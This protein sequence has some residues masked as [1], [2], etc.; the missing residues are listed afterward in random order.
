MEQLLLQL[1]LGVT[2]NFIYDLAKGYLASTPNP[3]VSELE[4]KIASSL[5]IQNADIYAHKLV[6]FLAK[7]GDIRIEGTRIYA[8]ESILMTSGDGTQFTFG[9]NSKSTTKNSQISAGQGAYIQ[10]QGGAGI[11]QNEDGGI[12]FFT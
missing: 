1:G 3:S 2:S 11:R 8:S 12:S 5:N 6:E 9:N 4:S 7:R 10:G